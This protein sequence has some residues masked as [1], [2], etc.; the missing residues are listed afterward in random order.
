MTKKFC[1]AQTKAWTDRLDGK[2]RD[3]DVPKSSSHLYSNMV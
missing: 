1:D 2:N 3:L